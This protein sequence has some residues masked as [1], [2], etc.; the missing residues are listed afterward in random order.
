MNDQE[1]LQIEKAERPDVEFI[2]LWTMKEALLKLT[3]QGIVDNLKSVLVNTTT[4]ELTTVVD[5]EVRYV[6][7]ICRPFRP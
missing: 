2:R 3:G 7:S 5:P 6:Y 4:S 1:V